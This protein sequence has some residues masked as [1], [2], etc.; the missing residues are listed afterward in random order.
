[1]FP[2]TPAAALIGGLPAPAATSRKIVPIT[3]NQLFLL[4]GSKL[5]C[6]KKMKSFKEADAIWEEETR[7]IMKNI[8]KSEIGFFATVF[9]LYMTSIERVTVA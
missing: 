1:M 3:G 6:C 7:Q 2:G 9:W 8:L 5:Q 4:K